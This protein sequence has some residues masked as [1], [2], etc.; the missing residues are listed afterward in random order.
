MMKKCS[1]VALNLT[2]FPRKSC[3]FP[4]GDSIFDQF[5]SS[6]IASNGVFSITRSASNASLV[7]RCLLWSGLRWIC[8]VSYPKFPNFLQFVVGKPFDL[9]GWRN[10]SSFICVFLLWNGLTCLQRFLID[11]YN[12]LKCLLGFLDERG[13]SVVG[14]NDEEMF[15]FYLE[16]D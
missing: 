4:P 5:S 15:V 3:N 9:F 8:S 12:V 11:L 14:F 1:Y 13:T 2:N 6:W 7:S 16:F 10:F